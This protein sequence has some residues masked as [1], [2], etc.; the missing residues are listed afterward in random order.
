MGNSEELTGTAEYLTLQTG[1]RINR[2]VITGF[3]CKCKLY[4]H[5]FRTAQ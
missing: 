1:C 2:C 3:D 5:L 4:K